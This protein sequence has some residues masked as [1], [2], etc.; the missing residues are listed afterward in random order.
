MDFRTKYEQL[1]EQAERVENLEYIYNKVLNDMHWDCCK[2]HEQDEEHEEKWFEEP[3]CEDDC[4]NWEWTRY[5]AYKE[6]LSAIEK[7][8]K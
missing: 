8:A 5:L 6:V 2:F 1:R 4:S 3:E 7:L